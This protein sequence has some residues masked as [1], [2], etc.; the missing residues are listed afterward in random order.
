MKP[1]TARDCGLFLRAV[2]CDRDCGLILRAVLS[3]RDCGS[4]SRCVL[5]GQW[6]FVPRSGVP[7]PLLFLLPQCHS[8]RRPLT[9]AMASRLSLCVLCCQT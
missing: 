3:D 7:R 2:L 6:L 8:F 4:I 1:R 9:P 5:N